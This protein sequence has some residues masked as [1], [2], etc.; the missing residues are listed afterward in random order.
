[1]HDDKVDDADRLIA[2]MGAAAVSHL[3]ERIRVAVAQSD[4]RS[5]TLLDARLREVE[6]R[7]NG[8]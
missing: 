8:R 5:V 2:T 1:M 6:R 4:D 3:V 7:L